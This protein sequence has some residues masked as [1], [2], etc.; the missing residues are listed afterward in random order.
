MTANGP[1]TLG[2]AWTDVAALNPL[3]LVAGGQPPRGAGQV[4][5]DKHSADVG[6]FKVGDKVRILTK[7]SPG[8]LHHHRPRHLGHRGQRARR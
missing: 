2:M 4:V 7:A 8:C 3:R 5:I 1:P 6:H